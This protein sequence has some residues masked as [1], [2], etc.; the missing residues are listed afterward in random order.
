MPSA[1]RSA[2]ALIVSSSVLSFSRRQR[3]R[4]YVLI[5]SF[6]VPVPMLSSKSLRHTILATDA[7]GIT[8]EPRRGDPEG[9][10]AL[11][12]R[13]IHPGRGDLQFG[14]AAPCGPSRRVDDDGYLSQR[15][16]SP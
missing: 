2:Y 7:Q 3:S 10:R 13:P 8:R 6:M 5:E 16:E 4:L 1:P 9:E 11:Q 12:D 15:S 14:S